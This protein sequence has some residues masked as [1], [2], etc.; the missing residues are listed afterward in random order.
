MDGPVWA[1]SSNVWCGTVASI[2]SSEW[3][4][5]AATY[6]YGV[7]GTRNAKTVNGTGIELTWTDGGGLPMLLGQHQGSATTWLIY[8]P[9]DIPI[10]QIDPA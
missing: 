3:A 7:D 6:R 2:G 4:L 5:Q 8:G 9:G 10:E 1:S